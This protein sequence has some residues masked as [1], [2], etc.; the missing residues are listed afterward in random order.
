MTNK[1]KSHSYCMYI[2]LYIIF[3]LCVSIALLKRRFL[4][5]KYDIYIFFNGISYQTFRK[6][7]P[8]SLNHTHGNYI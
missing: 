8:S 4:I 5:F 1:N 6:F 2:S 7:F 3:R